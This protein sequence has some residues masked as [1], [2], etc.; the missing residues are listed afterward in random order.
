MT[1]VGGESSRGY[2]LDVARK[3]PDA[4]WT[5]LVI[6]PIALRILPSLVPRRRIT[7][8]GLSVSSLL[9]ALLAGAAFLTDHLV[10]GALLFELHFL[11][12]CLDGKLA[13]LRGLQSP[14]G[15]FLDLAC[16][17]VGTSWCFAALGHTVLEDSSVPTLALLP[18]TLY[19]V[20]TW[21]TLHRSKAGAMTETGT[22]R[23]RVTT[24]LAAHRMTPVPY[25]VEVE[26]LVLFLL[27][28]TGSE[29]LLRAGLAVAAAFFALAAARNLRATYRRLPARGD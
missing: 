10:V 11:L 16:D 27:P 21:S 17:L 19:V 6:D 28:L 29:A 5:V 3:H 12:D 1:G 15:G 26:T 13:R 23:G 24:W 25:G 7:P 8:D 18:V 4:W 9:L 2:D 22:P 20:Y 14:R